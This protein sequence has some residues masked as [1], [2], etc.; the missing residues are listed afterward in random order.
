MSCVQD[1]GWGMEME[2]HPWLLSLPVYAQKDQSWSCW[3]FPLQDVLQGPSLEEISLQ[4]PLA[5]I[6]AGNM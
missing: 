3:V 6:L 5:E 1:L 4:A 2:R